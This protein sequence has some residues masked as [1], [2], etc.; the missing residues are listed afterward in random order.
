MRLAVSIGTFVIG[1][2]A[3]AG[4]R[5][6]T[7]GDVYDPYSADAIAERAAEDTLS[8][9][10]FREIQAEMDSVRAHAP[11]GSPVGTYAVCGERCMEDQ[12][13]MALVLMPEAPGFEG[14]YAGYTPANACLGSTPL[15]WSQGRD[16]IVTLEYP[17][18]IDTGVAV[19]FV[20][21]AEG[22]YGVKTDWGIVGYGGGA[23]RHGRFI[24]ERTGPPSPTAC[25]R[26]DVPA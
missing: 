16:G 6:A 10:A 22:V 25:G 8:A 11:T 26:S 4:Y 13:G 15:R 18:G 1:L 3:L 19:E 17:M 7:M 23:S 12:S 14:V 5:I 21:T 20:V 24:G 9:R 2:L